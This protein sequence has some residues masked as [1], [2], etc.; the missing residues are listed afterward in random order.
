MASAEAD[1]RR[2][3]ITV[4]ALLGIFIGGFLI[5]YVLHLGYQGTITIGYGTRVDSGTFFGIGLMLAILSGIIFIKN[6][7]NVYNTAPESI[8]T[9]PGNRNEDSMCDR[10]VIVY[11]FGYGVV[12]LG[13]TVS[14]LFNH[15]L[16]GAILCIIIF[17]LL[18]T[19]LL[20]YYLSNK[21][22]APDTTDKISGGDIRGGTPGSRGNRGDFLPRGSRTP[23]IP[24]TRDTSIWYIILACEAGLI[25]GMYF[26]VFYGNETELVLWIITGSAVITGVIWFYANKRS[27]APDGSHENH[28]P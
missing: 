2:I 12:V 22:R 14:L 11:L 7:R 10:D 27:R 3:Y 24:A 15:E 5:Y 19:E 1:P 21:N 13:F 28:G 26:L 20:W 9:D 6:M 4:I 23:A 8:P 17:F 25:F 18:M 16:I